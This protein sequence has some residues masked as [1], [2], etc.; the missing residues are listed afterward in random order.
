[1]PDIKI[2]KTQDLVLRVK[3][4]YNPAKLNL[5]FKT[6]TGEQYPYEKR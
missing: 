6:I 1:M 3:Q 5:D 2:Y 4:N